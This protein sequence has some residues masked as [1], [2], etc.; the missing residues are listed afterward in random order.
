MRLTAANSIA[1]FA[2][3]SFRSSSFLISVASCECCVALVTACSCNNQG[4]A[5]PA[6]SA[7]TATSYLAG[8]LSV[9]SGVR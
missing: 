5:A 7:A 3:N 9:A 4:N 1:C 2:A 6:I 8:P